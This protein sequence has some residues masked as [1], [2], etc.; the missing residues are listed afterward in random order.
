V[1]RV[2][3]TAGAPSSATRGTHAMRLDRLA[4]P[5]LVERSRDGEPATE[6][7]LRQEHEITPLAACV[8][9]QRDPIGVEGVGL[10]VQLAD[11]DSHGVLARD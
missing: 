10:V 5:A 8:C 7:H 11:S 6:R 2:Q 9:T 1:G 4:P 3:M